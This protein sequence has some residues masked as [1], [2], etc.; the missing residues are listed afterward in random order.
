MAATP[1]NSGDPNAQLTALGTY[2]A[3][4][5]QSQNYGQSFYSQ[6]QMGLYH[7]QGM[8]SQKTQGQI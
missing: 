2:M 4:Q 1:P 5:N 8:E 6:S 7:N 3:N